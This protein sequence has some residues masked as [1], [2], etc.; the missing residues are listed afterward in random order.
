[1]A[2][3]EFP[4]DCEEWYRL[5]DD[6]TTRGGPVDQLKVRA[7]QLALPVPTDHQ[8]SQSC[9]IFLN[10]VARFARKVTLI[11][12]SREASFSEWKVEATKW[13]GLMERVDPCGQFRLVEPDGRADHQTADVGILE[14]DD[15]YVAISRLVRPRGWGVDVSYGVHHRIPLTKTSNPIGYLLAGCA[16][17][18]EA[19][20]AAVGSV[21]SA[22]P[23]IDWQLDPFGPATRTPLEFPSA[24]DIG[25]ILVLGAG[26]VGA[27][28]VDFLVA[29]GTRAKA[30]LVDYDTVS[31]TDLNRCLPFGWQDVVNREPKVRILDRL[32]TGTT[33][34]THPFDCDYSR[35]VETQG[36]GDFDQVFVLANELRAPWTVQN[37]LPPLAWSAAT[38]QNWGLSVSRHIPMREGCVACLWGMHAEDAPPL[39]CSEGPVTIGSEVI[40]RSLPFLSPL[41][42]GLLL[43]RAIG[44]TC[45]GSIEETNLMTADLEPT[46]PRAFY[47]QLSPRVDCVCQ[48]VTP[49]VYFQFLAQS[50]FASLSK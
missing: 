47:T 7:L 29:T 40:L 11:P 28:F 19:F 35:F 5:R 49:D 13:V 1:M 36:R 48:T 9:Q 33:V 24:P 17:A 38:S 43:A 4:L 8:A 42:A 27:N 15:D 10:L 25:R 34:V 39:A 32:C 6:R 12:V 37:N 22:H 16:A 21:V 44:T 23:P 50:R 20:V 14:A 41:A 46:P 3:A 30:T 31:Y 26:G 45:G 2:E 18:R